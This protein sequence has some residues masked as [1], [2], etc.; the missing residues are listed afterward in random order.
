MWSQIYLSSIKG[1]NPLISASP[2]C[3][4]LNL[5]T[6]QRPYLPRA[7]HWVLRRQHMNF[8]EDTNFQPVTHGISGFHSSWGPS[9]K[10]QAIFKPFSDSSVL[11]SHWLKQGVSSTQRQAGKE[12]PK[13]M[14]PGRF[15][16][17]ETISAIIYYSQK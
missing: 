16:S 8:G 6:S 10:S 17:L 7:S 14:D 1:T 13:S 3:T 4:N 12:L 11:T 2:S 15:D 9:P 5:I